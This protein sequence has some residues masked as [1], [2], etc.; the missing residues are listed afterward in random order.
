L[1]TTA[2]LATVLIAGCG[3]S[4]PTAAPPATARPT[5]PSSPTP[6]KPAESIAGLSAQQIVKKAQAAAKAAVSVRVRGA[7][8]AEDGTRLKIDVRVARKAG[9]GTLTLDGI[10]MKVIVVGRTAYV[11]GGD[12]FW[13]QE[14]TGKG[15][16]LLVQLLRGKWVKVS[17]NAFGERAG[18]ASKAVLFDTMVDT[19][20][21]AGVDPGRVGKTAVETIDGIRCVGVR[22]TG[23]TFWVNAA[24]ARPVRLEE[25]GHVGGR[26]AR[27]SLSFS[28]YNQIKEPK[29]PPAAQVVDG[30]ALGLD[31]P[32]QPT[33]A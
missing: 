33:S 23:G 2:A 28:E 13:R 22:G 1:I 15:A 31:D 18:F 19:V 8:T 6:S 11:Q 25:T 16:E 5:A 27:L 30:K 9:S 20:V 17:L 12:A 29:A 24:N 14:S 21:P 3:G 32:S 4:E 10:E 7:I 26:R